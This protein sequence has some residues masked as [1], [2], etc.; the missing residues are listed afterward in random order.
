[1]LPSFTLASFF[2]P[3]TLPSI[4]P[5]TLPS[6]N[7]IVLRVHPNSFTIF[8][9]DL[10][11]ISMKFLFNIQQLFHRKS[12]HYETNSM[13]PYSTKAFQTHQKCNKRHCGLGDFNVTNKQNKQITFLH[14][15]VWQFA[16]IPCA[17][18]LLMVLL[19]FLL[20][21]RLGELF[22][23]MNVKIWLS[24]FQYKSFFFV[25]FVCY[26]LFFSYVFVCLSKCICVLCFW[27]LC[28][29]VCDRSCV[30]F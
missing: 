17:M 27:C 11:K 9:F 2:S 29:F 12:K 16:P 23:Q 19:P 13:H 4:S 15:S 25:C 24:I 21:Y 1:M 14:Y 6:R 10:N 3:L 20:L 18:L 28:L 30:Y 8:S 26:L 5:L 22:K 7:P